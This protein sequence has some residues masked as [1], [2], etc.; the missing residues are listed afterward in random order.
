MATSQQRSTVAPQHDDLSNYELT[1]LKID[2]VRVAKIEKLQDRFPYLNNTSENRFVRTRIDF[3]NTLH[4]SSQ[5]QTNLTQ[6]PSNPTLTNPGVVSDVGNYIGYNKY[7]CD[8]EVVLLDI[9]RT[10]ES[11]TAVGFPR[12]GPRLNIP[13]HKTPVRAAIVC[14]GSLCPGQND[15]IA[16]VFNCLYYNY[17]VDIVYGIKGGFRGFYMPENQPWEVL[18][19][20]T[21]NDNIGKGGSVLGSNRGGFDVEKIVNA[22]AVYCVSQLYLIGG[23]GSHLA[24]SIIDQ[25]CK[26]Q[27]IP[28]STV[29]IPC[30]IE[31]DLAVIDTSFGFGSA[32]A[33]ALDAIQSAVTESR[34]A[35][36]GVGIVAV[37]GKHSGYLACHAVLASSNVCACLIPEAGFQ[38][39]GDDGLLEYIYKVVQRMSFAVIVVAEGTAKELLQSK[40]EYNPNDPIQFSS[41]PILSPSDFLKT[42][43]DKYFKQQKQSATIRVISASTSCRSAPANPTDRVHCLSLSNNAVHAAMYGYTSC[44]SA[45]V[46]NRSVLIPASLIA[47]NSPSELSLDGRTF[48]RVITLTQQPKWAGFD[49]ATKAAA[50]NWVQTQAPTLPKPKPLVV[51]VEDDK[52]AKL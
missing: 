1:P 34:C 38:L 21:I 40:T 25:H 41:D 19:P 11:T 47:R 31:N 44:S 36:S 26:A 33:G 5:T 18:S 16:E 30:S 51:K 52:T 37:T 29:C 4:P 23:D 12:A 15:V 14:S 9:V 27:N 32:L 46:N 48:E 49:A 17:G 28:L 3:P 43:V 24:A 6:S 45:I 50:Y 20:Q 7:V 22:C 35:P 13:T 8:D 10:G 39:Y 2:T 42:E